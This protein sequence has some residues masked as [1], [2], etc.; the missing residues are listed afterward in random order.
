[1]K[2]KVSETVVCNALYLLFGEYYER[3]RLSE[4]QQSDENNTILYRYSL[5]MKY[6][7]YAMEEL[8]R[9]LWGTRCQYLLSGV[10]IYLLK[11]DPYFSPK[12]N[13]FKLFFTKIYRH[14]EILSKIG[15]GNHKV[16][17]PFKK[18]IKQLPK[19]ILLIRC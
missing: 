15:R 16:I 9:D 1:M 4:E 6:K 2:Q 8:I 14:R 11:L 19:K 18:Y 12:F 13:D 5:Q 3:M 7:A 17:F 10:L